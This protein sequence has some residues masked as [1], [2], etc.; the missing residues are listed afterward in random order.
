MS[1]SGKIGFLSIEKPDGHRIKTGQSYLENF[2][3]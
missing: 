2:V 3:Y 1:L